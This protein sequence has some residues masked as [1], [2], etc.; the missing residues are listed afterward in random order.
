M[1]S[2]SLTAGAVISPEVQSNID[3]LCID[4]CTC[5]SANPL[6]NRTARIAIDPT[7]H[8]RVRE[9]RLEVLVCS[10][11]QSLSVE[12]LVGEPSRSPIAGTATLS[13]SPARGSAYLGPS[14]F[15]AS[16]GVHAGTS[17]VPSDPAAV[18]LETPATVTTFF[19]GMFA[20]EGKGTASCLGRTIVGTSP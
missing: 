16:W 20:I 12:Q 1:S 3:I 11:L 5:P 6:C 4:K 2:A 18:L 19:V 10:Q 17:S 9:L 13:V 14:S 7:C 8:A 15:Y